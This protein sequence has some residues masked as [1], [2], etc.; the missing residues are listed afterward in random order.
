MLSAILK[1]EACA[2]C[3]FCCAFRRKSLWETPIFTKEN[4]EA[5]A[6]DPTLSADMLLP[7]K[8]SDDS[9]EHAETGNY[10]RYDLSGSYI[11]ENPEEEAPCPYLGE[12]GCILSDEEK[13]WDCKIWPLRVMKKEEDLV[14]ALTPTCPEINALAFS[15]VEKFVNTGL[16][17][18]L[19]AYA[20][21][22]PYLI[23]EYREGFPIPAWERKHGET[24][25]GE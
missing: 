13:P 22:H 9:S 21:A 16:R 19:F 2:K 11:T 20:K 6:A 14:I 1:K 12:K 5:I 7:V 23:K 8:E 18:N 24:I 17:E 3:R 25:K 15:E 4:Y 10:Y